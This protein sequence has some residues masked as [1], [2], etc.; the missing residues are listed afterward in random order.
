[1]RRTLAGI[2]VLLTGTAPS[3]AQS[4]KLA[5]WPKLIDSGKGVEAKEL[6]MTF[7]N[8]S[9]LS[10]RVEAQKCLANAALVGHDET[11]IQ[12]D[13]AGGGFIGGGYAPEAM[14][15]SLVHLNIA[16]KLAPQD[17][18]I[19]QGRLHVLEV[20][21]RYSEMVK[22][23]DESSQIYK[24]SDAL[25]AWLA[26]SSELHDLRQYQAGLDFML[27]LDKRYPNQPDVLG[28]L[29]AFLD[30][31]KRD[32]EAIPYLLKAAK[33]APND[34]INA[35][36]LARAYDYADQIDLAEQWYQK[37]LS[38]MADQ[39]MLAESNCLYADF[40]QKKLHDA[41]RACALEKDCSADARPACE[42]PSAK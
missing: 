4:A 9:D 37:G 22:A 27:V 7:V 6:C 17:L 38:L 20:S 5:D 42:S 23:I 30:L 34:P 19:H 13:H 18:S 14:D 12:G 26:Y 3:F 40:V 32:S 36:D 29:G 35:W 39:Q 25:Q 8:A 28:N 2:A 24:G 15:E 33:L 16:L 11:Q 1:M 10:Q 41:K 31:L 21:G